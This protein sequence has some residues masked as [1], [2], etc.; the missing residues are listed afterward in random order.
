METADAERMDMGV[1]DEGHEGESDDDEE[2]ADDRAD[3]S[4]D[5][6]GDLS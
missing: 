6:A 5:P 3:I 1:D 4:V 2:Q